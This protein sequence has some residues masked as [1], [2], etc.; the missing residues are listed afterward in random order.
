MK[1]VRVLW[2]LLGVALLVVALGTLFIA[3]QQPELLIDFSNLSFC[4]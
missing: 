3:Y 4:A 1:P 2:M